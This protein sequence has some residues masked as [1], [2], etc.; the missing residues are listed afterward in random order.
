[1][2]EDQLAAVAHQQAVKLRKACCRGARCREIRLWRGVENGCKRNGDDDKR[3]GP[4][5]VS[6]A[7]RRLHSPL[8]GDECV[9]L[10]ARDQILDF[11]A[12][13]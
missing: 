3:C 13:S 5:P 1:M 8:A 9:C 2:F 4:H 10:P 6:V 7:K 11:T 12:P